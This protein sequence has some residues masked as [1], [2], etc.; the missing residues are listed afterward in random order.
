M[1]CELFY[2]DAEETYYYVQ[3]SVTPS[4]SRRYNVKKEVQGFDSVTVAEHS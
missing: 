1:G 2:L 3:V 4:G